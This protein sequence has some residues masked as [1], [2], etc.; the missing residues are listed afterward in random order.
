MK[1]KLTLGLCIAFCLFNSCK[2]EDF[3]LKNDEEIRAY[4]DE[5]GLTAEKSSSGLY[6]I[7]DKPGTGDNP[8][9]NSTVTVHYHGYYTDGVVFDSSVD[10]GKTSQFPLRNVIT[11]W[12][13][14][15]PLFKRGGEGKLLIPSHLAYGSS[16]PPGI[17]D[18]AVLVFDIQLFDFK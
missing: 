12:Q 13:E 15:I 14:G 17:R 4:L 9:I 2:D 8:N 1:M 16:A 6:Y 11:G 3:E 10:R 5:K 7:I 18:N